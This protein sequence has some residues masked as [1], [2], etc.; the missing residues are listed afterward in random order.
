MET[1]MN[2]RLNGTATER[3]ERQKYDATVFSGVLEIAALLLRKSVQ[4]A[5]PAQVTV[6]AVAV[7]YQSTVQL[8]FPKKGASVTGA[9]STTLERRGPHP[10][11]A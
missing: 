2:G 3:P 7:P 6:V 9:S 10:G 8:P 11:N 4:A 1:G 5:K